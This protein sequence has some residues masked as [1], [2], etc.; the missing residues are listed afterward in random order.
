M[1]ILGL[2]PTR[3]WDDSED[4]VPEFKVGQLGADE[5]GNVF[6]FVRANGALT[7]G[8]VVAIDE[9]YDADAVETTV[10]TPTT[11][12]GLPLGV[13]VSVLADNDWGWVQRVG[14]CASINCVSDTGVH[15]EL[16][17]T[18]SAGRL[19][20]DAT[21]GAEKVPG[22]TITGSIASNRAAGL[23]NW[24]FIGATIVADAT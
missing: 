11:G 20:D 19:D 17:T 6:Q 4:E 12:Q 2:D 3:V 24:P 23:L 1:Y 21:V 9:V 18:A 14:V 8:D 15:T 22:I 5:A 13:A 10:S 7:V 16:N